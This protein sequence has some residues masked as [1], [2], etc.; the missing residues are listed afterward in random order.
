MRVRSLRDCLHSSTRR[1]V[2][3]VNARRGAANANER[4]VTD[5]R[6]YQRGQARESGEALNQ[7]GLSAGAS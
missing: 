5:G 4:R 2:G 1:S 7:G 3:L 6:D